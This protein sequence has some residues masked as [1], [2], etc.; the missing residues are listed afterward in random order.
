MKVVWFLMFACSIVRAEGLDNVV[1]AF[2]QSNYPFSYSDD[3]APIGLYSKIVHDVFSEA[4]VQVE[5]VALPWRR[6]VQR[7][8]QDGLVVAGVHA[9]SLGN[10]YQYSDPIFYEK[11]YLYAFDELI[12]SNVGAPL[13]VNLRNYTEVVAEK[14]GVDVIDCVDG[15]S[16]FRMLK[17]GRLGAVLTSETVFKAVS[18][19][20]MLS[21]EIKSVGDFSEV[22]AVR[23][24]FPRSGRYEEVY[25]KFNEVLVR[26]K[27]SGYIEDIQEKFVSELYY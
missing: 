4:G 25:K 23:V 3:G 11:I 22:A 27:S 10:A 18:K 1:V 14:F 5:G 13:G 19:Y 15:Y 12:S 6:I 9:D 17:S 26:K 8:R 7:G 21:D 16:C 20:A 2:N 24:A